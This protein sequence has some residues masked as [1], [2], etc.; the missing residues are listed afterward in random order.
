MNHATLFIYLVIAQQQ[1]VTPVVQYQQTGVGDALFV[2]RSGRDIIDRFVNAG[3][4]V[5]VRTEFDA[6]ALAPLSQSSLF[7]SG[8]VLCS[9]ES[10]MLKEMCQSSLAWLFK[11]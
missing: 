5:K 8:E 3:I 10:H 11:Y 9:I 1:R 2:D 6:L 7:S 4:S